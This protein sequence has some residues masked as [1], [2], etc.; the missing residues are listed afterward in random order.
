MPKF[1]PIRIAIATALAVAPLALAQQYPPRANSAGA[2]V[3]SLPFLG[4]ACEDLDAPRRQALK[5]KEDHGI[6]ITMVSDGSPA[7]KAGLREGDVI[8]EYNGHAVE[9]FDQ[10]H[11]L[12]AL[13]QD[14]AP[15][16]PVK[17][18][19]SRNGVTQTLTAVPELHRMVMGPGME[20]PMPMMPAP[21]PVPMAPMPPM[22]EIPRIQTVMPSTPLGIL[23]EDLVE[24]P[25]FAEFFGVK[26]GVLVKSVT[27]GSPADRA[28]I[29]AGDVIVKINDRHIASSRDLQRL[30]RAQQAAN[31]SCQIS[32][33]RNRKEMAVTVNP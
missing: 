31:A 8:L 6:V 20:I 19:I 30:M 14:S 21:M 9:S 2:V 13:I 10:A 28:G 18:L 7:S 26:D 12:R 22:P 11:G 32:V 5:V 29:K 4:V 23:G 15:G 33:M 16:K 24:E 3:Q 17:V 1:S 25:Q 27:S